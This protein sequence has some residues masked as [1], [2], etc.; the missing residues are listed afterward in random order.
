VTETTPKTWLELL[1]KHAA[2]LRASGV[3]RVRAGD[4]EADLAPEAPPA[5]EPS[6]DESHLYSPDPLDDPA[7]FPGGRVP[8]YRRDS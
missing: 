4:F 7:T 6:T 3:T 1:A 5:T 2:D 8:T